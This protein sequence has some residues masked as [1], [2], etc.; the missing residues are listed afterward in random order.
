VAVTRVHL[1]DGTFE[2]FRCFFGAPAAL[3]PDGREV[4]AVRGILRSLHA[5]I[6]NEPVTHG[7]A[8][9]DTVIESFR[10]DLFAGYKTGAGLP[11]ELTGQFALA[12]EA[13]AALGLVVWGMIEFEADDAIAA[14]AALCAGEPA[15]EQVVIVSPD[16]DFGQCVVGQRVICLDRQRRRLMDEE[17]VGARF[18]V[19]PASIPDYLALVGDDAD[20]IPG[21]PGWGARSTALVL[22]RHLHL[23][24]IPVDPAAWGVTVRGANKLAETLVQRRSDALLYRRL[25]TLRTD[26][27]LG[28]SG[29]GDLAWRGARRDL[30][31]PLCRAIGDEG[32]LAEVTRWQS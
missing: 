28:I 17:G 4:G 14:G 15:V 12:E 6:R 19:A 20:G 8:A 7:A 3:A 27:P 16:K 23:D 13:A 11:P 21:L 25:A 32:F 10:N 29:S 24:A 9:F 22:A 1:I 31:E 2:L 26:V 5:L 18:G 30:L